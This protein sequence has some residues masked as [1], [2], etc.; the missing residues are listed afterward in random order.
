MFY[1]QSKK[2]DIVTVHNAR[3][4]PEHFSTIVNDQF[5]NSE[6]PTQVMYVDPT[7]G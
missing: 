3:T 1:G 6:R 4:F 5:E 2:S 7:R